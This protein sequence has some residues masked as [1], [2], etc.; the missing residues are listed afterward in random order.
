MS[1]IDLGGERYLDWLSGT[2]P[3]TAGRKSSEIAA[4]IGECLGGLSPLE[5]GMYGYEG[6][7]SVLGSGRVFWHDGRPEMGVHFSLPATA[8]ERLIGDWRGFVQV[9]TCYGG[10]FTRGD[11]ALDQHETSMET[12]VAAVQ[13]HQ[14]VSHF[15]TASHMVNLWDAGST[16]YLGAVASATRVRIYDKGAEQKA[17]GV[18]VP[19][20]TWVR[21]EVQFRDERSDVV[22]RGLASGEDPASYVRAVLDFR[23]LT[24]D[25]QSNRCPALPWWDTW[26][27]GVK[28]AVFALPAKIAD[29]DRWR[30][31]VS[32]QVAG[33]LAAIVQADGG[34]LDWLVDEMVKGWGRLPT[35]K[36]EI[37]LATVPACTPGY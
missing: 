37:A 11:V 5:H 25:E 32:K 17:A 4:E 27:A 23:D 24:V 28:G 21:C 7:G 30:A 9:V 36:R 16:V 29:M 22:V 15:R 34:A 31:W 1:G 14:V 2:V 35:W 3:V 18:E 13:T 33:T 12:V 19:D 20:G 26:L 8:L 10:H 6:G